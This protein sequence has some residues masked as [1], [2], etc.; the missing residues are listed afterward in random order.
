M[1]RDQIAMTVDGQSWSGWTGFE[2]VRAIDSMVGS[3][4]LSSA[5]RG[6]GK[7]SDYQFRP[8]VACTI[9]VDD[10]LIMTGW[11]DAVNPSYDAQS[12]GITVSGR[13]KGCDLVDCSAVNKPGSW[14]NAKLEAIAAD[15]AKPFGVTV[16]AK[17]DTGAPIKR[18]ALEQGESVQEALERLLRFR[19]LLMVSDAQGNIEIISPKLSGIDW[20]QLGQ[21]VLSAEATHDVSERFSAYIVKGQSSGDD[22][23][24]GKAASQ[25][26]GNALDPAVKRYRPL[27]VVAEE[28]SSLKSLETRA[29]W[30][31]TTRAGK[32]QEAVITVQGLHAADGRLWMPNMILNVRDE[33]LFIDSPMLIVSVRYTKDESG[34]RTQ[35]NL[36]PPEA[37]SQQN[38]PEK[39]EAGRVDKKKRKKVK[40]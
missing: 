17:A 7:E 40:K 16:T 3:F 29:K 6:D 31:A 2:V 35:L 4:S 10:E 19:G 14:R 15:L 1:S 21:A 12:H 36:A 34:T 37:W 33:T 5:A 23:T 9:A 20:D 32:S 11:V 13:D 18:F 28:Q 22:E 26:K 38:V 25:I 27:I 39:R 24:N 8:D 30:E